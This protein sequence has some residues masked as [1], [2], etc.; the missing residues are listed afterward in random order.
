MMTSCRNFKL[1]FFAQLE[2][3]VLLSTSYIWAICFGTIKITL[4]TCF[5]Y[6]G[7]TTTRQTI[8][9]HI[10]VLLAKFYALPYYKVQNAFRCQ[11]TCNP[12]SIVPLI[13]GTITKQLV[14]KL[15]WLCETNRPAE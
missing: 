10:A 5:Y 15:V 13:I 9:E 4:K 12:L 2:P 7:F 14:R 11:F 6:E 8:I 1:K 3:S